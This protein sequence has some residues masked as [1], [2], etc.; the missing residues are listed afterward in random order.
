LEV[1]SD[2]LL[3]KICRIIGIPLTAPSGGAIAA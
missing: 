2:L 3:G 1:G